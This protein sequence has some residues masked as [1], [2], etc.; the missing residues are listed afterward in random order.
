MRHYI[1]I[2][3]SQQDNIKYPKLFLFMWYFFSLPFTFKN[4]AVTFAECTFC[5]YSANMNV[6]AKL[7]HFQLWKDRR[8]RA[9]VSFFLGKIQ[10]FRTVTK[11]GGEGK[12][13]NM[14]TGSCN[15]DLGGKVTCL[16]RFPLKPRFIYGTIQTAKNKLT[17]SISHSLQ[18]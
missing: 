16:Q 12:S 4:K 6:F 7:N 8:F 2:Y 1:I 13:S 11:T 3:L 18:Y 10:K 15:N 14:D 17:L 5:I 9:S